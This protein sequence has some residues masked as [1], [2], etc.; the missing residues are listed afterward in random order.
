MRS[1]FGGLEIG[2]RGL[3]THQIA[4]DVTSHNMTNASTPGFSR[5]RGEITATDPYSYPAF[6]YY[7][8]ASQLGTGVDVTSIMRIRD[9]FI[10]DRILTETSTL[11]RWES[12]RDMLDQME[13]VVNE[14]SDANIRTYTDEFWESLQELSMKAGDNS[15][16]Y[17]LRANVREKATTLADEIRHNYIEYQTTRLNVNEQ[18]KTQVNE[19]NTIAGQIAQLN[20]QI[21]KVTALGQQPNDLLDQRGLY[22]EKLSKMVGFN[23][24][25]D[26]EGRINITIGGRPLVLGTQ[27]TE[28]GMKSTDNTEGMVDLF[29]KDGV[30]VTNQSVELTG[31]TLKGLLEIRDNDLPRMID[32][33]NEFAS[34]F[35]NEINAIHRQGYGIDEAQTHGID[36]FRG[37]SAQDIEIGAEIEEDINKI[38]ASKTGAPGNGEIALEMAQLKQKEIFNN[39]TTT[40]GDYLGAMVS[41]LGADSETSKAQAENQTTLIGNLDN[42][43]ESICGVSYDEE[44]TNM[45]KYQ[46]GYNAAAK[47]IVTMDEM[48]DVIVNGLKV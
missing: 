48:L 15:V 8:G 6:T 31:G 10:D 16:A 19:I 41:Q 24:F 32:S 39:G 2:R 23:H 42:R 45:I 36:F 20:D 18:I 27:V 4:L 22:V 26:K 35:I 46:Q 47:I 25:Y 44:M 5:Q 30:W 29:W 33:L 34:T 43:R 7:K 17:S 12:R 38:G 40:L 3:Q 1:T 14:P 28:I 11:G 21:G 13:L 9:Q 37:T